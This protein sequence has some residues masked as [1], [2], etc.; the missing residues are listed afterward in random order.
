MEKCFGIINHREVESNFGSLCRNRPVYMLP[1]GGRYRVVDIILSNMVANNIRNVALFTGEKI[2]STMDHISDGSPWGLNSRFNGLT[3]FPPIK[4]HSSIERLGDIANLYSSIDYFKSLKEQIAFLCQGNVMFM[5]DMKPAYDHFIETDT[6]IMYFYVRK[7]DQIGEF[8]N[9][10]KLHLDEEGNLTDIG[11]NLG[12]D[13]DFNMSTNA[14][15]IKKDVLIDIINDAVETGDS[16]SLKAAIIKNKDKYK[17]KGYEI[18][19]N[20]KIIN[21]IQSY[22]KANMELLEKEKFDKTFNSYGK[23]KTKTKD[24]PPTLYERDVQVK[25]SL[26]ANGCEIRGDVENSIIFRGVVIEKGVVVRNSIIMQ[27][28]IIRKGSILINTI[29][30]KYSS[31]GENVNLMGTR[32][33]PYIVDKAGII[34]GNQ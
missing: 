26:I 3:L 30:D 14:V 8:I 22:Y 28:S 6:D 9:T 19:D 23:V 4:Q 29:L 21:D 25:N 17:V 12:M 13:I 24:E 15:L 31:I 10:D 2:R 5:A 16:Q 27:K 20:V 7:H 1:Y 18:E 33:N 32:V 11:L 34:E